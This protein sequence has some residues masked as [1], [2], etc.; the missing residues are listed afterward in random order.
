MMC[1]A[2]FG[3]AFAPSASAESI[4]TTQN[5]CGADTQDANHYRVGEIIFING[6]D[7]GTGTYT[8]TITG[9]PGGSSEDPNIVVAT[10][11]ITITGDNVFSVTGDIDG[12]EGNGT[13]SQPNRFC[14]GAYYVQPD[15]GGEYKANVGIKNDNYRVDGPLSGSK[16]ASVTWTR[17]Y[18]WELDKVADPTSLNLFNGQTG[19]VKFT[20]SATRS[21]DSDTYDVTGAVSVSN[22]SDLSVPITVEDCLQAMDGGS[23]TNVACQTLATEVAAGV[24]E[25]PYQFDNIELDPSKTYQNLV[26]FSAAGGT[27]SLEATATVSLPDT[28]T[29]QVNDSITVDDDYETD[30]TTDASHEF[31]DT[32]M[33]MYTRTFACGDDAGSHTN[34]ARIRG[35]D[36][37]ADATVT[38][39][40]YGL[41]VSKTAAP[42]FDRD[43]AWSIEKTGPSDLMLQNDQVYEAM[44]AIT[45]SPTATD[46]NY[47]VSGVIT[48]ENSHPTE[49]ATVSLVDALTGA[50]LACGGSLEIPAASSATC[51]YSASRDDAS[52][53]TNTATATLFGVD[54]SGSEDFSF[55]GVEPSVVTDA[56]VDVAD[57]FEGEEAVGLGTICADAVAPVSLSRALNTAECG[58]FSL[59]NTASFITNDNAETGS[60]DHTVTW[61]VAGCPG[62]ALG[63]TL[64]QGYWKTHNFTFKGD[65]GPPEDPAWCLFGDV[66]GDG[67][68][69]CEKEEFFLSGQTYYEAMWTPTRGNAYYQLASQWIAATLNTLSEGGTSTPPDH[70][71]E[72]LADAE[73]FL[74]ST[75]PADAAKLKGRSAK[76]IK[77]WA[78]LLAS[79]NE[80]NEGVPHCDEQDPPVSDG[81]GEES[82]ADADLT[83]DKDQT[84]AP[85]GDVA[86]LETDPGVAPVPQAVIPETFGLDAPAPNPARDRATLRYHLPEPS[87][88]TLTVYDLLG[89]HVE[90]VVSGES[91]EAGSYTVTLE[92]RRYSAGVYVVSIRTAEQQTTRRLTVTR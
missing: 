72:A 88:V 45:L 58:E 28:P 46:G 73:A 17:T 1:L 10:G 37:T 26:T 57:Q 11:Q 53:G 76:F 51:A 6:A 87:V 59:H 62:D 24:N 22:P 38:V 60:D 78:S 41:T 65:G 92:T 15:D 75:T 3:L 27:G 4:W 44:Y 82:V 7:W 14:F 43:Y 30:G 86:T 49:A 56:C 84:E 9:N 68:D 39:N 54:Y 40:C 8:W 85:G 71:A 23:W 16:T 67:T 31:S 90:T 83:P 77:D 34:T 70:V 2:A 13:G 74:A 91:K 50:V 25:F 89:R 18:A 80:G 5:A 21:V 32:D 81:V 64:T 12:Q 55:D 20:I 47:A 79:F 33:W 42:S 29:T 66:D 48:V 69:E 35:T 36:T 19:D 63:C 52:S 61:T